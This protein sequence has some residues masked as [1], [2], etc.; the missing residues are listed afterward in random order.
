MQSKT[1]LHIF[2]AKTVEF[3]GYEA[4]PTADSALANE[5]KSPMF[6]EFTV[7]MLLAEGV[8]MEGLVW[9]SREDIDWSWRLLR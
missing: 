3:F 8:N 4:E 1:A 6:L 7:P 2:R 5:S 9:A